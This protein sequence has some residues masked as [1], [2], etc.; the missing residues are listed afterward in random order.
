MQAR[1]CFK[2]TFLLAPWALISN[3]ELNTEN[4]LDTD[5]VNNT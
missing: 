4:E 1:L 3:N 5:P 2:K